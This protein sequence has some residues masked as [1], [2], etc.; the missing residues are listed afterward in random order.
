MLPLLPKGT[1]RH[2]R[3]VKDTEGWIGSHQ[4]KD[5]ENCTTGVAATYHRDSATNEVDRLLLDTRRIVHNDLENTTQLLIP[6]VPI[7]HRTGEP[8]GGRS[9]K[10]NFP[11]WKWRVYSASAPEIPHEA[12]SRAVTPAPPESRHRVTLPS[13]PATASPRTI[14]SVSAT[15]VS[16]LV[17]IVFRAFSFFRISPYSWK[18]SIHFLC[19]YLM[20]VCFEINWKEAKEISKAIIWT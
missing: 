16:T 13:T 10:V 2:H 15:D 8:A 3:S 9:S 1:R 5:Q 6:K 7:P 12:V 19:C 11:E 17:A 14:R 4:P 18:M 20:L